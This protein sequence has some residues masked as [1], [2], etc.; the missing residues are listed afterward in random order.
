[1]SDPMH[2]LPPRGRSS[3]RSI[4]TVVLGI[5]VV[6]VLAIAIWG[7]FSTSDVESVPDEARQSAPGEGSIENNPTGTVSQPPAAVT[8]P[9]SPSNNPVGTE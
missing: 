1:M 6:A 7:G 5:F 9:V 3:N 8:E 2:P 4:I